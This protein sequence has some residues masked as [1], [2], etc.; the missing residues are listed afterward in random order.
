MTQG[1]YQ[2]NP[3]LAVRS[4]HGE[5][6]SWTPVCI[7]LNL[8]LINEIAYEEQWSRSA[9]TIDELSSLAGLPQRTPPTAT[10]RSCKRQRE[11]I[12]KLDETRAAKARDLAAHAAAISQQ[13]AKRGKKES[14]RLEIER[15]RREIEERNKR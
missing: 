14:K 10:E 4:G 1:W 6:E 5:D 9:K 2:L 3:K 8:K 15:V 12:A 7:A 11:E 13:P